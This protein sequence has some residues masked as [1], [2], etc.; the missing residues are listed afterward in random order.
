MLNV[1]VI[2]SL[3]YFL[4]KQ[5]IYRTIN[6]ERAGPD[7]ILDNQLLIKALSIRLDL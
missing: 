3:H 7:V 4:Q 6:L 5:I 2:Y 1:P